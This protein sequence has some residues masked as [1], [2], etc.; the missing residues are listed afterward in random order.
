LA[1][2]ETVVKVPAGV[3][4]LSIESG[5]VADRLVAIAELGSLKHTVEFGGSQVP[6]IEELTQACL[7]SRV[8][9]AVVRGEPMFSTLGSHTI[10]SQSCYRPDDLEGVSGQESHRRKEGGTYGSR[11]K[12]AKR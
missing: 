1:E 6:T 3:R 10:L 12:Q 5:E 9:T 2:G 7:Q 11:S 8:R 4:L